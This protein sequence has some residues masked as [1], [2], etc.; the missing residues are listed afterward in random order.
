L[1]IAVPFGYI[2]ELTAISAVGRK[3]GNQF[4]KPFQLRWYQFGTW[5]VDGQQSFVA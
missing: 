5:I 4:Q 2:T 3:Y 1:V